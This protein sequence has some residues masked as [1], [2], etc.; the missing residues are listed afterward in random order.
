[1]ALFKYIRRLPKQVIGLKNRE[2]KF[3]EDVPL[4]ELKKSDGTF[5]TDDEQFSLTVTSGGVR[6]GNMK[7]TLETAEDLESFAAAISAAWLE[8]TK[9]RKILRE[10]LMGRGGRA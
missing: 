5:E 8:H 6:V 7:T 3:I 9:L 4:E 2:V 1:M 10:K